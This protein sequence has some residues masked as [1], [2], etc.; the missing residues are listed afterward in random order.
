MGKKEE[1][2][3]ELRIF[4]MIGRKLLPKPEEKVVAILAYQLEDA[5]EN[6]KKDNLGFGLLYNGQNMTIRELL[7]K[8]QTDSVVSPPVHQEEKRMEKPHSPE[9]ISFEQFRTGLMLVI[10]KF[11]T[12]PKDQKELKRIIGRLRY[13]K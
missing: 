6:A 13:S 7:A 8:L 9:R 10:D 2:S 4:F 12:D 5:F 11:I 3:Q 1:E